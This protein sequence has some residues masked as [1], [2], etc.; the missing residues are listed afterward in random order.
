MF[1]AIPLRTAINDGC[2]HILAL[3]SR[4]KG[5]LRESTFLDRVIAQRLD[6]IKKGLGFCY[7]DSNRIYNET[8]ALIYKSAGSSEAAPYI[9]PISLPGNYPE[10]SRMEKRRDLILKATKEGMRTAINVFVP[11]ELSIVETLVP[12]DGGGHIYRP[13]WKLE[14]L[15]KS[16]GHN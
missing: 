15:E 3:L 10:I 6:K 11:E 13:A 14:D 1:E 12:V 4:P 2:T 9:S 7:L 5:R 8:V 16:K